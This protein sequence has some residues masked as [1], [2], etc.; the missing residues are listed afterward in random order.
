MATSEM[1]PSRGRHEIHTRPNWNPWRTDVSE[2]P[3][4]GLENVSGWILC[5]CVCI[6]MWGHSVCVRVILCSYSSVFHEK[7]QRVILFW[8]LSIPWEEKQRNHEI[9]PSISGLQWTLSTTLST[10]VCKFHHVYI[11]SEVSPIMFSG[12]LSQGSVHDFCLP[13]PHRPRNHLSW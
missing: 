2:W 1:D 7:I 4:S 11:Y 8:E 9:S 3:R 10:P 12:T 6:G 13:P 5:S